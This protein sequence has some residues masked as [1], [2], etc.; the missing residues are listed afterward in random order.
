[1]GVA[2]ATAR[3]LGPS[4]QDSVMKEVF[5]NQYNLIVLGGLGL[6]SLA[7]E[8]F[9]PLAV[10]GLGELV[11]LVVGAR[12]VRFRGWVTEQARLREEELWASEVEGIAGTQD[13]DTA[14]R[15][16]VLGGALVEIAYSSAERGDPAFASR[17]RARLKTLLQAYTNLAAAHRRMVK[18]MGSGGSEAVDAEIAR[19]ARELADEKD[20]NV[21]ISLRQAL[22][23]CQRR[24]KR[25]EQVESVGRDLT[26]KMSTFE[27]SLEFARLQVR[28]GEPEED[29]LQALEDMQV[30]A[31]I[32]PQSESDAVRF[33]GDRRNSSSTASGMHPVFPP[34]EG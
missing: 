15:L 10:A 5:W 18:L 7:S 12:S 21:R 22:A 19:L 26:V 8:S 27:A 29:I 33:L 20:S 34:T 31:R 2:T 30:S 9:V 3:P 17:V 6:F 13:P 32:D 23:L 24:R 11:W 1:M 16:R 4:N 28:G 14:V 25:Y